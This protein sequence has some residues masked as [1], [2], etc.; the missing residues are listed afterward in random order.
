MY[1][2]L[3]SILGNNSMFFIPSLQSLN[4]ML[5]VFHFSDSILLLS[6]F[7]SHQRFRKFCV[8][9]VFCLSFN[10]FSFSCLSIPC[11]LSS[12][13]K[14]ELSLHFFGIVFNQIV[15]CPYNFGFIVGFFGIDSLLVLSFYSILSFFLVYLN[16]IFNSFHDNLLVK[17]LF[18]FC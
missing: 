16:V 13:T 2:G 11:L 6:L 9:L 18:S 15:L 7:F 5:S 8:W 1:Q 12:I 4:M 14:L 10:Y 3:Q 17:I